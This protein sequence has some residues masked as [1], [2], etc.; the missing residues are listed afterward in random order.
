[1]IQQSTFFFVHH[2]KSFQTLHDEVNSSEFSWNT[3]KTTM[4]FAVKLEMSL[5]DQRLSHPILTLFSLTIFADMK[6][7]MDEARETNKSP[8]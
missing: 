2:K 7:D 6:E 4:F 5:L 1:L 8:T 3:F